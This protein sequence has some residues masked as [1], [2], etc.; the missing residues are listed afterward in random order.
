MALITN[1][2]CKECERIVREVYRDET[3]SDC[4]AKLSNKA[5]R[6]YF[7][8]LKGLTVEERLDRIEQFL[9]DSDIDN[10][11]KFIQSKLATY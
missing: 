8:G 5:R 3:C 9:Y 2:R 10:K 6:V 11:L 4:R 1:F 7:A